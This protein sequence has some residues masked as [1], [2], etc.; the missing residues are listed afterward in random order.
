MLSARQGQRLLYLLGGSLLLWNLRTWWVADHHFDDAY[1]FLRYAKIFLANGTLGWN[2]GEHTYGLTSIPYAFFVTVCY[3]LLPEQLL[4]DGHLLTLCSLLCGLLGLWILIL[5]GQ[6][7]LKDSPLPTDWGVG[8]IVV[9]LLATTPFRINL[10]TGM[11]TM[12]AFA[13][14]AALIWGALRYL[15]QPDRKHLYWLGFLAYCTFAVRP[16][17]GLYAVLFPL[18]LLGRM[19]WKEGLMFLGILLLLIALDTGARYAYFGQV[20]PLPFYAK[21]TG[22]YQAYLGIWFWESGAYVKQFFWAAMPLLG[23]LLLY[24]RRRAWQRLLPF[25]VPLL[26][27][28]LYYG[29]VIQIMGEAARFY[30]P[31]YPFVFIGLLTGLRES[32]ADGTDLQLNWVRPMLLIPVFLFAGIFSARYNGSLQRA[33]ERKAAADFVLPAVY[34]QKSPYAARSW[35]G[36]MQGIDRLI[37]E[38]PDDLRLAA[39]EHGILG[40]AH[41][42]THITCL[43]GLHNPLLAREGFTPAVMDRLLRAERP[44]LIWFPKLTYPELHYAIHQAPFFQE[45]YL[46]LPGAY[47]FGLGIRKES[48]YFDQ[49]Q[50]LIEAEYRP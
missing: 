11:D 25:V 33:A 49:I 16:D 7:V 35:W 50:T 6:I 40:N 1:M 39:S 27:T 43:I 21:S 8:G 46:F 28:L 29:T 17:N 32:W 3:Q 14:N 26:L 18:L 34:Q 13:S 44:D 36:A 24:F 15:Q 4:L 2:P 31:S 45:H 38:L 48:P 10:L 41:P 37:R 47:R 9:L 5:C 22:L 30:V 12:L 23:L 19:R 42:E 20:L